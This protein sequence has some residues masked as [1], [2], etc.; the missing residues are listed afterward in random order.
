MYVWAFVIQ[1]LIVQALAPTANPWLVA[2]ASSIVAVAVGYASWHL[3]EV[4]AVRLS[5]RLTRPP[6]VDD[7]A[8]P[9][10]GIDPPLVAPAAAEPAADAALPA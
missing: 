2:V 1:Q 4:R 3:V 10:E 8:V 7:D 5:H 6:R 9:D